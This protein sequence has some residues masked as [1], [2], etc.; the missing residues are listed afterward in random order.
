M[1]AIAR[2]PRAFD[3]RHLMQLA[4]ALVAGIA[5]GAAAVAGL[6]DRPA[7]AESQPRTVPAAHA[8]APAAPG[9]RATTTGREEY[10]PPYAPPA[11]AASTTASEQYQAPY[12]RPAPAAST[13]ASE[14]YQAPYTRPAPAAS[15]T[16]SEEYRV[17]ST[18]GK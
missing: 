8:P 12:T 2:T 1:M 17:Q 10:R 14:Q 15:T 13:T 18:G 6:G 11:P 4:M 16:A 5:I 3:R 7:E 9:Q